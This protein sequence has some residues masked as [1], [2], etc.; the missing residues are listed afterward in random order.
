MRSASLMIFDEI[1]KKGAFALPFFVV[2]EKNH[3]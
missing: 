3:F 2:I 1:G